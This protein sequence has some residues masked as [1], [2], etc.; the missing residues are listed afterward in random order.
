MKLEKQEVGQD[1]GME[2]YPVIAVCA[3]DIKD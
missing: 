2:N 3:S 1:L